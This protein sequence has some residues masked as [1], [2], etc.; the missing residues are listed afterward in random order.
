M[1]QQSLPDRGF[2]GNAPIHGVCLRRADNRVFHRFVKLH[3][4]QFDFC[5][6]V[7][8][9]FGTFLI[10]DNFGVAQH[11]FQHNDACLNFCLLFL[12][13]V[14][15]GVFGQVPLASCFFDFFRYF[16][17]FDGLEVFQFRLHVFQTFIGQNNLFFCH[18]CIPLLVF[19]I[20]LNRGI[21]YPHT[22][23]PFQRA[24]LQTLLGKTA[25]SEIKT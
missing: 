11:F 13:R 17:P 8:N 24:R 16:F 6:E 9:V 25:F 19:K 18:G 20:Y 5:A 4:Q 12:R 1:P 22:A 15:F 23:S 14:I 10:V 3:I 7:D 2:I 21:P